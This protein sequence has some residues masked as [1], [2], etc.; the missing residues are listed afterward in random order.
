MC[1]IPVYDSRR[2]K[3]YQKKIFKKKNNMEFLKNKPF[4]K[5]SNDTWKNKVAT[6]FK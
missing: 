6:I 4:K 3:G 2:D 1:E 5:N